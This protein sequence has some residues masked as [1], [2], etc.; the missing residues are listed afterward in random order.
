MGYLF[1]NESQLGPAWVQGPAWLV[2]GLG[3]PTGLAWAHFGS[4]LGRMGPL[5]PRWSILH[6][7]TL[8]FPKCWT[9][10]ALRVLWIDPPRQVTMFP[11]HAGLPSATWGLNRKHNTH[12]KTPETQIITFPRYS[13]YIFP[14]HPLYIPG[15]AARAQPYLFTN[16]STMYFSIQYRSRVPPVWPPCLAD[17]SSMP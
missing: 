1:I 5:G 16:R 3:P 11:A 15:S 13:P 17:H 12:M 7:L 8:T 9:F 2:P 4:G 6:F 14:I 10:Q